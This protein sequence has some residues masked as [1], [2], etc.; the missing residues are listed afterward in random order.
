MNVDP[1]ISFDFAQIGGVRLHYAKAGT[2]DRLVILLHGFP[3]CWY[4]WRHQL[5]ALSDQ[6]TVVAPDLRGFNLS[7][8]PKAVRDYAVEKVADDVLG[9]IRHFGRERAAVIGHDWGAGVAWYLGFNHPETL[10]KLGVLQVPPPAIWKR[11]IS[12]KQLMASWYMFFFQLPWLPELLLK[13]W[14]F[15]LLKDA[16][17]NSTAQRGIFTAVDIAVFKEAWRQEG[18]VTGML[19]YYRAN[20]FSR[21]LRPSDT[22]QR[23]SVPTLFVYGQQDHAILPETVAGVRDVVDAEFEQYLVSQSA[24]WIQQEVPEAMNE[25]LKEFLAK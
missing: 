17:R 15:R 5:I 25:I 23:V 7:D 4:S 1:R 9:L 21:L 8:K 3:E 22:E 10:T 13:S 6:Y 24:H 16:L 20:F 12:L 11:N 14:D 2:G 19:N 18:A